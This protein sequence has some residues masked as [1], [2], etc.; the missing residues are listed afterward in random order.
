MTLC[1]L[2]YF[3]LTGLCLMLSSCSDDDEQ[4]IDSGQMF[5]QV[6]IGVSANPALMR[7]TPPVVT[8]VTA[9]R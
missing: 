4:R 3:L 7:G 9:E 5:V 8:T 2:T 1:R 6:H